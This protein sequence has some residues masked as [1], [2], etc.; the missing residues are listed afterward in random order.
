MQID[1][2]EI[3]DKM[4]S[5][6]AKIEKF[7]E[8]GRLKDA[9]E[10]L[11]T[12]EKK[13]P[14]DTDIY[15][16]RAVILIME[17]KLDDAESVLNDGLKNDSCIFDLLFNLGYTYEQRRKYQ[18][19]ADMYSKAGTVADTD[20]NKLNVKNALNN[21][22]GLDNNVVFKEKKR[23]VFFVKRGMDSFIGDIING[24]SEDYWTRKI[25]VDK[26]EQIDKGMEWADICWFEWCDELIIYGSKLSLAIEKKVICRLH[27]YEAFT[28][29]PKNVNWNYVDKLIF[30]AQHIKE[31]VLS[32]ISISEDKAIVIYNGIDL[33]KYTFKKR[34]KG[35]NIAYV[36][37]IN[38][39]KGPMLLLHAFK[40][41][42]DFDNRYVLHIAGKFQDERDQLY[43]NQMTDELQ[44]RNSIKFDGW[45][46]DINKWLE[47]KNYII[48]TSLL[49]SQNL[50]VMQ[51][52]T[53][54]IKPLI[55]NFVGARN[56]YPSKYIWNTI[57]EAVQNI[58]NN[59][60]DS[61]EYRSLIENKYNNSCKMVEIKEV[62]NHVS[63][64]KSTPLEF[65][66]SAYWN[67]RLNQKFD[68][69]GVGYIGLGKIYNSYLYK[70]RFDILNYIINNI[71]SDFKKCDV[72]EL[73]PGIG[74]FT[75]Y[76]YQQK[77][78][79]YKG[80]D[81]SAKSVF[82]LNRKY[83]G[84][85]FI[86][87]D[88]SES[89]FYDHKKYDLIF[90][91]DVLLHITNEKKYNSTIGHISNS[92]KNSG[93]IITFDPISLINTKSPSPHVI[94]RDIDYIRGVLD[95]YDMEIV[96][97][98]PGAFFMNYP[99]DKV[100]LGDKSNYAEVIFNTISAFFGAPQ[101]SD[102]TKNFV[103]D[104]LY[105]FEKKCLVDNESGLSQKVLLIKKKGNICN[106][107]NISIKDVWNI[108]FII[109]EITRTHQALIKNKQLID[110]GIINKLY[111]NINYFTK[112]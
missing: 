9:K 76:F 63:S 109:E 32:K 16:M 75:E 70:V 52:M 15:S 101:F 74:M 12:Y 20:E 26:Y 58:R 80:I 103:A 6:K 36:G 105:A 95:N 33:D 87:G 18:Q 81:I 85:E 91:A 79:S 41:I 1:N 44:L 49:E 43:F 45:Q 7:I 22:K 34:E 102:D 8:Q 67:N 54:G 106:I 94:I 47:D 35:F 90:A 30:V 59:N 98:L 48:C 25:I 111:D 3:L 39:K 29:Y 100:L 10:A 5:V 4:K 61:E 65:N 2:S 68:I 86:E 60:Y 96:S 104:W 99:F 97:L 83:T 84:F 53:K 11:D 82:E 71:F 93:F 37:Y 73:G 56:V 27:S 57:N 88:I 112:V 69:E 78:K 31:N 77:V 13:I 72:L 28:D 17:G 92:L 14:G 42:H 64:I 107:P 23:L 24:L 38:Y 19:A 62:I 21:V 40:A 66:Y 110:S 108:N 46:T 89:R 50:S 51:A 55:H